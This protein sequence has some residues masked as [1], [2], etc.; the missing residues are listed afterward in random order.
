MTSFLL[1]EASKPDGTNYRLA[2]ALPVPWASW[3]VAIG[4]L[5]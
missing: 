5:F 4:R 2:L 3:F 1:F